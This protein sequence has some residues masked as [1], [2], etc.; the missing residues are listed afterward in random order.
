MVRLLTDEEYYWNND[1][2]RLYSVFFCDEELVTKVPFGGLN[3]GDKVTKVGEYDG[4][5]AVL[6]RE[7]HLT[8]WMEYAGM[9]K[10][11][12]TSSGEVR[13]QLLFKIDPALI[14]AMGST[15]GVL[16]VEL[17]K[18]IIKAGYDGPILHVH[19]L[20]T[21]VNSFRAIPTEVSEFDLN[22]FLP[23]PTVANAWNYLYETFPSLVIKGDSLEK[24][25]RNADEYLSKL[26]KNS[27]KTQKAIDASNQT[28]TTTVEE[29]KVAVEK[30]PSSKEVFKKL[31]PKAFEEPKDNE[32]FCIVGAVLQ[33]SSHE[34]NLYATF[35]IGGEIK[36]IN[37]TYGN[38]WKE[39]SLNI[40]KLT[41]PEKVYVDGVAG[42]RYRVLTKKDIVKLFT[43]TRAKNI[44][45]AD[46]GKPTIHTQ[47]KNPKIVCDGGEN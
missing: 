23:L 2:A 42:R 17:A 19:N 7:F 4:G 25:I 13:E 27:I 37:L 41:Y 43:P 5:M 6:N 44:S 15:N 24:V 30:H 14:S 26:A 16:S 28:I 10:I 9:V 33:D 36:V 34:N 12:S 47:I 39:S 21:G 38:I 29:I 46:I 1:V 18:L 32:L 45:V 31:F 40:R 8:S 11:P 35:E 22:K 3:I 20:T